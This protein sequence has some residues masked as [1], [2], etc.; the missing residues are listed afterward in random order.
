VN[1]GITE[2]NIKPLRDDSLGNSTSLW[3]Y[4]NLRPKYLNFSS[5][6][7][8]IRYIRPAGKAAE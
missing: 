4:T 1:F 8:T 2:L 3:T 7:D 6:L 5:Q